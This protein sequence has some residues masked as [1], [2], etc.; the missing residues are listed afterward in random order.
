M[1]CKVVQREN[2]L[3]TFIT[4]KTSMEIITGKNKQKIISGILLAVLLSFATVN[5]AP[6]DITVFWCRL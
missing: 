4:E 3:A 6:N 1:I 2:I 5:N